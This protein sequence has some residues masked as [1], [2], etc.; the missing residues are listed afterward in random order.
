MAIKKVPKYIKKKM[1]EV[2]R[3]ERKSSEIMDEIEEWLIKNG[4]DTSVD[5]GLRAGDGIGLDELEY[6][7]DCTEKLCNI[8]EAGEW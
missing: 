6:G 5:N 3:L 8:I 2:A 4:I 7:N 1:H